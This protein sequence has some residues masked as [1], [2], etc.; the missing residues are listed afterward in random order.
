MSNKWLVTC[1]VLAP[2]NIYGNALLGIQREMGSKK[3]REEILQSE[4]CLLL[5]A[6]HSLW[7]PHS[8]ILSARQMK[9]NDACACMHCA[10]TTGV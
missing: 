9:Y 5:E 2:C 6:C 7:L 10:V 4:K 8:P 1:V 3:I